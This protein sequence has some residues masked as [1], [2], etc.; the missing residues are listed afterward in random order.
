MYRVELKD[1]NKTL[2][3]SSLEEVPNVPCGVESAQYHIVVEKG[4]DAVPNVPCGVERFLIIP[5]VKIPQ[6]MHHN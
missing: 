2:S 4:D 6:S 3:L 5:V 1:H